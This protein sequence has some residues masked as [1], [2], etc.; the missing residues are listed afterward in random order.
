[1]REDMTPAEKAE[2]KRKIQNFHSRS[3]YWMNSNRRKKRMAQAA[4]EQANK[5]PHNLRSS[6]ADHTEKHIN[7]GNKN[8]E[9]K[10]PQ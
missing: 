8:D 2:H 10:M 3:H 7:G 9:E 4:R 5:S 6:G 1:M